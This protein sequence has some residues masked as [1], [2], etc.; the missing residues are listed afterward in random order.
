MI[1]GP[2]WP[3]NNGFGGILGGSARPSGSRAV[4]IRLLVVQ[5]CSKLSAHPPTDSRWGFHNVDTVLN[6]VEHMKPPH[7]GPIS[8]KEM[9]DICDT[10]GNTQNG[11]GSFIIEHHEP[12]TF[13]KFEPG[14]T[15]SISMSGGIGPGDIGS[16]IPGGAIP[17]FGGGRGFPQ[18]GHVM[19]SSGF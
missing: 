10:E 14:R 5:A 17:S 9:L 7:E 1:I 2:G 11:G 16:P 13:V 19:S 4:T 15:T 3:N 18:H 8:M 12:H 6:Q